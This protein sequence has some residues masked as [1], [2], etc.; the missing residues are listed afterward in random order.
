MDETID[1]VY[2]NERTESE[3]ENSGTSDQPEDNKMENILNKVE[4]KCQCLLYSIEFPLHCY[5]Y[6][7][8]TRGKPLAPSALGAT[9]RCYNLTANCKS[10]Q[11]SRS[12]KS[13]ISQ[14]SRSNSSCSIWTSKSKLSSRSSTSCSS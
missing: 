10:S 9:R 11:S 4:I 3:E 13:C 12:S 14:S 5:Y 7:L 1:Y 8:D 6:Y 2:K